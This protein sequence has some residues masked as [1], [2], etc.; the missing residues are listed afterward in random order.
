MRLETEPLTTRTAARGLTRKTQK[1]SCHVRETSQQ[2]P[3]RPESCPWSPWPSWLQRCG[4]PIGTARRTDASPSLGK[5]S[6]MLQ[7]AYFRQAPNSSGSGDASGASSN[8]HHHVKRARQDDHTIN[9]HC[10]ACMT[11]PCARQAPPFASNG[12]AYVATI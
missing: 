8:K 9:L 12:D 2:T 10:N 1:P 6:P 4:C 5:P 11:A 3:M 7:P